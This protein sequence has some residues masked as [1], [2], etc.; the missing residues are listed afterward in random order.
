MRSTIRKAA[1]IALGAAALS[2]VLATPASADPSFTPGANDIVGVGS[3]TTQF[4]MNDVANAYNATTPT[5]ASRVAS[6]DATGS[7]TI[8]PR[9]G[10]A[11]ITRPNGS[12]AGITALNNNTSLDF[13]RSS[14]TR[15]S[16]DGAVLF[17]PFAK[18]VIKYAA[19]TPT[20]NAPL[21][22][23][24][25]QLANIYKCSATT[26]TQV[27][28]TSSATIKPVLPQTNSGTRTTFLS[29]IGVTEVQVGTC[30]TVAQ[31]HDPAAVAGDANK[32]APF[33]QGRFNKL[34]DPKPIQLNTSGYTYTRNLY[35]VVRDTNGGGVANG[36]V[37]TR[38]QPFFG[39][40][41]NNAG[42]ICSSAATS[43]IANDGFTQ[44]TYVEGCGAAE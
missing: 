4:V 2:A 11:S 19:N 15:Q 31:E 40:G 36:G 33:S 39:D 41:L 1:V 6:W 18:D 28:G 9:A 29:S 43:V 38:L 25:A 24:A 5:P 12:S 30:V 10:A 27:G 13:S 8:T 44:L 20:T 32:I 22:L 17:L 26:W 7:A 35:N 34:A 23:T 42:W 14:R 16:S 21:N 3:D 37:D